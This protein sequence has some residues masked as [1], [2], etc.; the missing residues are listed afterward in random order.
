MAM[1]INTFIPKYIKQSLD[2]P[3]RYTVRA[4]RWNEL[5]NL[6]I[7]QGDWNSEAVKM[8]CDTTAAAITDYNTKINQHKTSIDH[9]SRY[10][11][12]DEVNNHLRGGDTI[13]VEEVFT[14]VNANLGDGTFSYANPEGTVFTGQLT[15]EGYQVFTLQQGDYIPNAHLME[16]SIEDTL[17]RSKASGGLVE[18][19][20]KRVALTDPLG[21]GKEVTFIYFMKIGVAGTGMVL[22]SPTKPTIDSV[23]FKVVG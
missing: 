23:W 18:L 15:S 21:N 6:V 10:Y 16:A 8:L 20:T 1:N 11:T 13:R 17:R 4:E 19:D 5:W 3:S 14:I 2:D 12:K 9:D 22:I 7:Q